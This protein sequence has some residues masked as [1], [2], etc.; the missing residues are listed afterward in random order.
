MTSFA[1]P[2]L[3]SPLDHA[4]DF[5]PPVLRTEPF[6]SY[7][8]ALLYPF[9][10][11]DAE[12]AE[13]VSGLAY[14]RLATGEAL[15]ALA[16]W[17]DEPQGGMDETEWRR[18]VLGAISAR[19]SRSNWT[20]DTA[21]TTVSEL[22][23][24]PS[25]VVDTSAAGW[26]RWRA[27]LTWTPTQEWLTRAS[28]TLARGVPDGLMFQAILVPDGALVWDSPP[29]WGVGLWCATLSRGVL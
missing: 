21:R 12:L 26:V 24:S 29:T 6:F 8:Q 11:V 3:L 10:R 25:V 16:S 9:A 19:V 1:Y 15:A 17:V 27:R 4:R 23:Q 5:L 14:P 13:Y 7:V 28:R 22:T 2:P 18:I 20:D